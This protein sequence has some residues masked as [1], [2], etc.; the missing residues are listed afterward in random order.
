MPKLI[1]NSKYAK[2][3]KHFQQNINKYETAFIDNVQWLDVEYKSYAIIGNNEKE[4]YVKM[5]SM[6]EN[7]VA[8]HTQQNSSVCEDSCL[9]FFF[10]PLEQE[11][12]YFNFELN[13]IGTIHIAYGPS[14]F[15]RLLI[16]DEDKTY[17]EIESSIFQNEDGSRGWSVEFKIQYEFISK[18]KK[19]FIYK[20]SFVGKCNFYKCG[21]KTPKQHYLTWSKVET[22]SPDFHRPEF[23]SPIYFD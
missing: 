14:R 1:Y 8:S 21:D 3:K 2:D 19:N 18:Y 10:S 16:T 11:D 5:V 12:D 4:I 22:Q 15:D 7:I 13:P 6:E 17:F 20:K 23:F 9:E